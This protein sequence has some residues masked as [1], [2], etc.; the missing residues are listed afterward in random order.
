MKQVSTKEFKAKAYQYLRELPFEIIDGKTKKV[1]AVIVAPDSMQTLSPL[2]VITP[3]EPRSYTVD[4]SPN[5][6]T[7]PST[8][9]GDFLRANQGKPLPK[10]EYC[11]HGINQATCTVCAW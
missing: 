4:Y 9:L 5:A 8:G 1:L 11:R 7:A 6:N 10:P 3:D 2:E